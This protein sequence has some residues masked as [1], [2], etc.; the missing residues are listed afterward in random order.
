MK[1]LVLLFAFLL[2]IAKGKNFHTGLVHNVLKGILVH[3]SWKHMKMKLSTCQTYANFY[4]K[5]LPLKIKIK[6]Q[7]ILYEVYEKYFK[8]HVGSNKD[9]IT[10]FI[11]I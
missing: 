8:N 9:I 11:M 2:D 1:G 4:R 7:L 3:G 6:N 10:F 5:K